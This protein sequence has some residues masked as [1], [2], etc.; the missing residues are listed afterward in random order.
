MK[1]LVCVLAGVLGASLL[2][3]FIVENESERSFR[4][5]FGVD[6]PRTEADRIRVRSIVTRRLEDK[7]QRVATFALAYEIA[8]RRP[9]SPGE[10]EQARSKTINLLRLASESAIRDLYQTIALAVKFRVIRETNLAERQEAKTRGDES[11][12]VRGRLALFS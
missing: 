12:P 4:A 6:V 8:R 7:A 3:V 9:L 10:T 2:F 1:F 5:I 11:R